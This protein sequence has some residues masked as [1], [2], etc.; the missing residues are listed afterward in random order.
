MT[1]AFCLRLRLGSSKQSG[2]EAATRR[3]ASF[4]GQRGAF[5][6]RTAV[7]DVVASSNVHFTCQTYS[8]DSL[9]PFAA[10]RACSLECVRSRSGWLTLCSSRFGLSRFIRTVRCVFAFPPS[11]RSPVEVH[12]TWGFPVTDVPGNV[13]P[14]LFVH[15]C[16]LS[17][18]SGVLHLTGQHLSQITNSFIQLIHSIQLYRHSLKWRYNSDLIDKDISQ[19]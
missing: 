18:L 19:V 6:V 13:R 10:H 15:R 17:Q 8:N 1:L 3:A 7:T 12:L 4:C 11:W 5:H 9:A 14:W 16:F 2:A